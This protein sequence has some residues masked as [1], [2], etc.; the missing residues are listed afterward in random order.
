MSI[1]R[2]YIERPFEVKSVKADGTIEGYASIFGEID[3][4]RDVVVPGAF[5]KSL[6]E[7]Y[8]AKNRKGVPM[9][10]QHNSWTPIGL[11]PIESVKEDNI[12]LFVVG[13]IN[14]KVQKGVENHALA[15]QGALTGLSIGY[16]TRDDEWDENGQ[17]RILREVD[18]WEISMVTFPAGD[19]ARITSV[20]SI[21]GLETLSDC[22]TLLRDAGF[23]KSETAAFVSRIK[24]LAVR[25][26]S[27]DRDA[28]AVKNALKI[29][30]S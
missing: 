27:A 24:A 30:R 3:S 25:S 8:R 9:L 15:D 12:G 5:T 13:Q 2:K 11:W 4:Y 22:E 17:V 28:L 16:N 19:S 14:M 10:D 18:L 21:S 7:R 20:K 29:L 6:D 23:S 26:E 1:H